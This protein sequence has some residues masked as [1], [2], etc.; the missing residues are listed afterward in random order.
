MA[1]KQKVNQTFW[2]AV[3]VSA[4]VGIIIALAVS[5]TNNLEK[6]GDGHFTAALHSRILDVAQYEF[7]N[8]CMA[9]YVEVCEL[10]PQSEY[11]HGR[12]NL[13][14]FFTWC[15]SK[16]LKERVRFDKLDKEKGK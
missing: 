13:S 2:Q 10:Y 12:A 4:G 11:C 6:S 1:K 15:E 7:E 14:R 16:A 9:F 3:G 8:C 5:I